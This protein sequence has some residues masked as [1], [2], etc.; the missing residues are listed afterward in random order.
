MVFLAVRDNEEHMKTVAEHEIGLI[1]M[2]IVNLY[3]FFENV[4]K[5]ISL[6]E[7][8]EFIDIGGPVNASFCSEEFQIGG[9]NYGCCRLCFG[10]TRNL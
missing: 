4:N 3:P 7:K 2:V 1:D 10:S 8:V 5:N 6:D 9:G